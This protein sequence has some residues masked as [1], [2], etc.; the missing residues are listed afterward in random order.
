MGEIT[1]KKTWNEPDKLG[2]THFVLLLCGKAKMTN[3]G[4]IAHRTEM[5]DNCCHALLWWDWFTCC[6][7]IS[8]KEAWK[9][10]ISEQS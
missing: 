6:H 4:C 10:Q 5:F 9:W 8:A 7:E 3:S 2:L 1:V